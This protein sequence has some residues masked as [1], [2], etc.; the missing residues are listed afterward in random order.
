[1]TAGRQRGGVGRTPPRPCIVPTCPNESLGGPRGS[2]C[3][4]CTVTYHR[5]LAKR[6]SGAYNDPAYK[7][8]RAFMKGGRCWICGQFGSDS[9]D[10]EVPLALGG[11]N[12]ASNLKPAHLDCNIGRGI[13]EVPGR[14]E[15]VTQIGRKDWRRRT[16]GT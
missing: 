9:V 16:P 13:K 1:M 2:R 14:T 3:Q 11:T 10:H 15:G 4:T 8:A 7:R 5:E 6:R 12:D